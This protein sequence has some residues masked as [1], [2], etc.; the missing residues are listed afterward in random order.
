MQD[1]KGIMSKQTVAVTLF[2]IVA[3]SISGFIVLLM[4]RGIMRIR[5]KT[6]KTHEEI[7][8]TLIQLRRALRQVISEEE[9]EILAGLQTLSVLND[10]LR[11]KALPRL[12]EL[13]NSENRR[14]AKQ[15]RATIE[16]ISYSAN[17]PKHFLI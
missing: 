6:A 12:V 9:E 5:L 8:N 13:T 11:L 10:P 17:L 2:L 1:K 7:E 14:I 4:I 15:A 16:R 3:F